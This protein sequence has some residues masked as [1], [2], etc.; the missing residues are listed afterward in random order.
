LG[1][2]TSLSALLLT[3]HS[4]LTNHGTSAAGT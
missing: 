4:G 2:G 1:S 3:I